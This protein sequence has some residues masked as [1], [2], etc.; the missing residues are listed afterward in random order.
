MADTRLLLV[1]ISVLAISTI[2]TGVII[3]SYQSWNTYGNDSYI[4]ECPS[5]YGAYC[6][7]PKDPNV[8]IEYHDL[9]FLAAN[10]TTEEFIVIHK[11]LISG[12]YRWKWF[13]GIGY[14]SNPVW[15][16]T[17]WMYFKYIEPD[18]EG[19]YNV[20]YIVN[21]SIKKPFYISLHS[22]ER[23]DYLLLYFKSDR[24]EMPNSIPFTP[25]LYTYMAPGLF[26][27][28]TFN[29]STRYNP[30]IHNI[31]VFVD[32]QYAFD[33][34]Q[35]EP[36]N[37]LG[38]TSA[39]YYDYYGGIGSDEK[40]TNLVFVQADISVPITS[41]GSSVLDTLL[42]VI[43]FA[44]PISSFANTFTELA[45]F[46]Y[47]NATDTGDWAG[48]AMIPWWLVI[49]TIY[50]PIIAIIAYAIQLLRGD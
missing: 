26:I 4:G 11:D 49:I 27:A 21:N 2:A 10:M 9:N 32:S 43:P 6:P 7:A 29:I 31:K 14:V 45:R 23:T 19:Y 12:T 47:S 33:I 42:D 30:N 40:G 28:N 8:R 20:L 48:E 24:I 35:R 44:R 18:Q 37:L 50:I 25:P 36:F 39:Y 17:A 3:Q 38:F 41:T 13:P 15:S 22:D 1:L 16:S 34:T 5:G 46:R